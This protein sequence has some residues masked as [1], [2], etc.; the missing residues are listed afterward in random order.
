MRPRPLHL[1]LG[2][3]EYF[4]VKA[5][6]VRP[7]LDLSSFY[8]RPG[9]DTNALALSWLQKQAADAARPPWFLWVHYDDCHESHW[10]P[11]QF[12]PPQGQN[13]G[14]TGGEL[15]RSAVRYEDFLV[16][17]LVDFLRASGMLRDTVV[18]VVSDHAMVLAGRQN[19]KNNNHVGMSDDCFHSPLIIVRPDGPRGV[20]VSRIT[21]NIDLAPTLLGQDSAKFTGRDLFGPPPRHAYAV[22]ESPRLEARSIFD[23][24]WKYI[25]YLQVLI[26]PEHYR[27]YLESRK[28]LA[29]PL[30]PA[31]WLPLQQ[32]A[33]A[34]HNPHD[35]VFFRPAGTRELYD[36]A[37]DPEETRNQIARHPLE[38]ARL[39]YVLEARMPRL[40]VARS[41]PQALEI[42]RKYGYW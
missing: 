19:S 16:G 21:Q 38:A 39:A 12:A 40:R 28:A 23:G 25:E 35:T 33:A 41:D 4:N 3:D 14:V 29:G 7:G 31:A 26:E 18:V 11:P 34:A 24:R 15:Y 5:S 6:D 36:M 9:E 20:R 32:E 37:S 1:G 27:P 42:L 22:C 13:G 10:T 8:K 2:F 30:D 17:Q